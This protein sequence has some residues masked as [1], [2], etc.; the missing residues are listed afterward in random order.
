M[1][2]FAQKKH[3]AFLALENAAKDDE[4]LS[5]AEVQAMAEAREQARRGKVLS[6]D[7]VRALWLE[8]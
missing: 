4:P 7:A 5:T 1:A 8:E 2:D 6:H 3:P